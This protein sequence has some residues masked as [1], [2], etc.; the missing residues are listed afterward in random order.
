MKD[1]CC[2]ILDMGLKEMVPELLTK[3]DQISQTLCRHSFSNLNHVSP[4]VFLYLLKECY[5]H[6]R[7][8]ATKKFRSLQNQVHQALRNSPQPG[9]ATFVL[10]CLCILPIFGIYSEGLS[11]LVI[12]ALH[13]L[14]K[15]ETISEDTLKAKVPAAHLFIN[16]VGGI[17]NLDEKII[18]KV[19][20]VFDIKLVD[21][22]EALCQLNAANAY[23]IDVA[24]TFVEQYIFRLLENRSYMAAV[25]LLEHFSIRQS[26]QSFLV[27]MMDSK[28]FKAAEKW[29]TF[30]GNSMLCI[31]VHEYVDRNMLQQAYDI[32]KKNNMRQ[33]FPNIFQKCKESL[34]KKLAEK[35]LWDLAE[36]K[37]HGNKQLIQYLI[38]LATE[39]GYSEKVDELCNRYSLEGFPIPKGP[40]ACLLHDRYLDLNELN[41]E[42]V[43]WVDEVDGL[44]D[45]TWH[46]E[47]CKVVGVDCE[48]KP[49][50]AKGRK[51]NKVSI[52]QIAS[53]K[54]VFIFDLIKLFRD[55]SD[56]LDSSLTRILQS[57]RILKLGYNFLCDIKQLA[58]S[59]EEMKCF[60][61]YEM[62]L[63]IQNVFKE[64]QGGLSGLS[65]KIL[66]A[67]LNKTR[68]N[69]NWEQRPLSQNQLEYAALDAAVLIHI[70]HHVGNQSQPTGIPEDPDIEWKSHIVSHM[71]KPKGE[72]KKTQRE[73]ERKGEVKDV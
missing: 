33:E 48:W 60:K 24:K 45:A 52:M 21:I 41:V 3:E 47:N 9:P 19:T 38:Y 4:V 8:K 1:Q 42:D 16:M 23:G 73:R 14:L 66:G 35:A 25:T 43:I 2:L 58:H 67:G 72:K 6:G 46:I 39:A 5:T 71:E 28:Q 44:R 36:A 30:M 40:G 26:G 49:N 10:W 18:L 20:E 50:Y 59:Y 68:R 37:T 56:S 70:F 34:L 64:R 62:L 11:H 22:M 29:A 51:P 17:V 55:A 32:I 13:R 57:P 53:K 65:K 54:V 7:L 27:M 69:S 15:R 61:H 12:S 63:D 31:L